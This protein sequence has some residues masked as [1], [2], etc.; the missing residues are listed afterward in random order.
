MELIYIDGSCKH[1]TQ[2]EFPG[3]QWDQKTLG[4]HL[5]YIRSLPLDG[6][7]ILYQSL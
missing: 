3:L 2:V 5:G 6:S 4:I 7:K 1:T